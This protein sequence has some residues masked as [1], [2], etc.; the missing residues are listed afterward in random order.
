MESANQFDQ[1]NP[2]C[3]ASRRA[4]AALRKIDKE[5]G[6]DTERRVF[7]AFASDDDWFVPRWYSAI[8]RATPSEDSQGIDF[9]IYRTIEPSEL[10]VQV[11]S[12]DRGR[13]EFQARRELIPTQQRLPI[14]V[15]VIRRS[16]SSDVIRRK[17]LAA[18][19]ESLR[20]KL[21][22]ADSATPEPVVLSGSNRLI[23][24]RLNINESL[25]SHAELLQFVLRVIAAI[26]SRNCQEFRV[27]DRPTDFS[28]SLGI[29][30]I[31]VTQRNGRFL[32]R[33]ILGE[34]ELSALRSPAAGR[35]VQILADRFIGEA[36]IRHQRRL[37]KDLRR[38]QSYLRRTAPKAD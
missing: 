19:G 8:A 26:R 38:F 4:R 28:V 29:G 15:T 6:D 11:K 20:L 31:F 13:E 36:Q 30:L 5:R 16:D 18:A 3:S 9:I 2:N 12:S 14:G 24:Q 1:L 22:F 17:V 23:R 33:Q 21:A 34:D 37:S 7:A 25:I 32:V 35:L 27:L 10:F